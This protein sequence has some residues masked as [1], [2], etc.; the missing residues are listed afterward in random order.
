M[1]NCEPLVLRPALA[2]DSVPGL[3]CFKRRALSSSFQV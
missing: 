2:I 1:K 3:S